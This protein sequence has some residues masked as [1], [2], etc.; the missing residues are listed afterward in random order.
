MQENRVVPRLI[1]LAVALAAS[2]GLAAAQPYPNKP[3]RF[4]VGYP[5]GGPT[6]I[7]SRELSRPLADA[8]GKPVVVD[9]RAGAAGT[10]GNDIVAKSPPDGYS[11]VLATS[12]MPIQ[13]TM[14]TNLPY[15]TLKDFTFVGTVASG[16]LVL[17]V[18]PSLPVTSV[19]DLIAL[20]K[21]KPGE[22]NYASPSSGSANHL[23]A[24][25]LK[26]QTG[27][28]AVHVPYK[29]AAPAEVDLMGGRVQFMFHTIAAALPRVK[30]G[31]LRAIAV[32][33]AKRSPLLPDVP[34]VSET[35]PGFEAI[36]WYGVLAPA[37]LPAD[38]AQRLNADLNSSLTN[39][40]LKEKLL[41]LGMEPMPG[42]SAQFVSFYKD[43]AVK[44]GKIVKASGAKLD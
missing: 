5:P 44:W 27:I 14:V 19:R 4:V 25:L 39:P 29:G 2:V 17:V 12:T 22:M 8:L 10:L 16:P 30:A 9:N 24:E 36:T 3:I 13:D 15:D 1:V 38:V 42:T 6:D 18:T 21:A 40:A 43:E 32:T 41:A 34:T 26:T 31:Q 35:V 11:V 7:V 23:A 28:E 33:S 20:A 37:N